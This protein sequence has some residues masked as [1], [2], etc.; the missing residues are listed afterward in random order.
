MDHQQVTKIFES[1]ITSDPG[2]EI[3][4]LVALIQP[5][6]NLS[7]LRKIHH[8]VARFF[9]G[10]YPGFRASNTPYHDLNHT[11]SVVLATARLLHG[12]SCSSQ[13]ISV[14][15]IEQ[16]LYSAYFHDIGLLAQTSEQEQSGAIYIQNHEERSIVVMTQYLAGNNCSDILIQECS[17]VIRYTNI[18][19]NP[20]DIA[21]SR[22]ESRLAGYVL[23]SADI[24]AQMA[25]RNYLE[26]LPFLFQELKE[27]GMQSHDSV[28]ALMQGTIFFYHNIIVERLENAFANIAQVMQ[29][30]FHRRWQINE[31]LYYTNI[32]NNLNYLKTILKSCADKPECLKSYLRRIPKS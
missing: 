32:T 5:D 30:H 13:E 19:L 9:A 16:A 24:L 2:D 11:Y 29:A 23:G 22:Q 31:N 7:L 17:F 14:E 25:D 15:V 6:F 4:A 12:L 27:G 21:F 10:T 3:F 26:R 18:S 28:V 1:G 20:E 8:D